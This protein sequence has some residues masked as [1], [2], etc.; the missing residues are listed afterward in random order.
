MLIDLPWPAKELSPNE[1][2][3]F[4]AKARKAKIHRG[5]AYSLA[6]EYGP[7]EADE[8]LVTITAYPKTRGTFDDDNFIARCKPYLDGIAQ[9]LEVNDSKFRIQPLKRGEV[10][11]GGN[12]RFEIEVPT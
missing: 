11:K 8:L 6:S 12:V 4:M 7:I 1:R 3:H 9:A 2:A 5:W 10:M